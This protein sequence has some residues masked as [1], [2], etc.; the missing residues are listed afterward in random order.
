MCLA[1]LGLVAWWVGGG[2]CV[3]M[4]RGTGRSWQREKGGLPF[5][6]LC[7]TRERSFEGVVWLQALPLPPK[8]KIWFIEFT[9]KVLWAFLEAS[10]YGNSVLAVWWLVSGL[11]GRG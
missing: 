2:E 10:H 11:L 9:V 5:C 3:E 6:L 1:R 4:T 8:L 7:V